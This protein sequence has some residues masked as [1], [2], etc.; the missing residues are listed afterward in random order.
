MVETLDV[1]ALDHILK[2]KGDMLP[3]AMAHE[4]PTDRLMATVKRP[5]RIRFKG[6]L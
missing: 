4:N 2:S 1:V 5:S 3:G 6:W